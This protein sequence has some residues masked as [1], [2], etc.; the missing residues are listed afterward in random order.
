MTVAAYTALAVLC[1]ALME[2]GLRIRTLR[3]GRQKDRAAILR[4]ERECAAAC[5]ERD[6]RTG[7]LHAAETRAHDLLDRLQHLQGQM[8][9]M[10]REGFVRVE[11][12]AVVNAPMDEAPDLPSA[13]EMAIARRS[14]SAA[15]R[16]TLAEYARA[17][18]SGGRESQQ[19]AKAILAGADLS[20]L[21]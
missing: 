20:H 6:A 21:V 10:K 8:V 17:E 4:L 14:R 15:V 1:L 5:A 2:A 7:A 9:D 18:L 3:R 11:P 16:E 13:V 19:V 12:P